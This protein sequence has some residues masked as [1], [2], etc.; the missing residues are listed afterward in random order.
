MLR[1]RTYDLVI[2]DVHMPDMDGVQL[3]RQ[4]D[5]EFHLPVICKWSYI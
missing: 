4:I 3:L 2:S 1:T 5:Q